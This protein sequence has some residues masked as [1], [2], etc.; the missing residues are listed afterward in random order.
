MRGADVT[1][2]VEVE[3]GFTTL[4]IAGVD[5][6]LAQ[7]EARV[8]TK[9]RILNPRVMG[10]LYRIASLFAFRAYMQYL[11]LRRSASTIAWSLD[12]KKFFSP[13]VSTSPPRFIM[14]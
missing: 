5:S 1:A 8:A 10:G 9:N 14:S 12:Q 11:H 3:T 13:M 4:G 2:T 6:T 7:E